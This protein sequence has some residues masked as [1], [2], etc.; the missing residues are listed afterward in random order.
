MNT[1]THHRLF[2]LISILV[3]SI[4]FTSTS[5]AEDCDYIDRYIKNVVSASVHNGGGVWR[6]STFALQ[7]D[8]W[9]MVERVGF[10]DASKDQYISV[11]EVTLKEAGKTTAVPFKE[12]SSIIIDNM[13]WKSD[14]WR[15]SENTLFFTLHYIGTINDEKR[16]FA[17]PCEISVSNDTIGNPV[18]TL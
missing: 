14:D 4:I 2:F 13:K 1:S 6:A 5:R 11:E 10:N 8:L 16:S 17:S 15:E 12:A 9:M 18:C 3:S 7:G